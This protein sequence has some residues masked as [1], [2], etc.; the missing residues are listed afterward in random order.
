M[1]S[2]PPKN[3]YPKKRSRNNSYNPLTKPKLNTKAYIMHWPWLRSD[4]LSRIKFAEGK[5]EQQKG[6]IAE[7]LDHI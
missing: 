1:A 3:M 2:Y 7:R 5:N 4:R 6:R